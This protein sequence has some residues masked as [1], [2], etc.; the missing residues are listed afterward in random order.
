MCSES[1]RDL[2]QVRCVFV[3]C[4]CCFVVVVCLF[5]V[6]VL[7]GGGGGGLVRPDFKR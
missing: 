6:A 7:V 1:R 4:C 5:V 2:L 3:F